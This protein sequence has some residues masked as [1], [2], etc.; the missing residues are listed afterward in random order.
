MLAAMPSETLYEELSCVV[1][2][3]ID[4][5]RGR[6]EHTFDDRET[7]DKDRASEARWTTLLSSGSPS[8]ERDAAR[9]E[10]TAT[11]ETIDRDRHAPDQASALLHQGLYGALSAEALDGSNRTRTDTTKAMETIDNDRH[12]LGAASSLVGAGRDLYSALSKPAGHSGLDRGRTEITEAT[13][14]IDLDK[15]PGGLHA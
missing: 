1:P 15:P 13:E 7:V 3:A 9:T 11:V 8:V 14:T 6:T 2:S 4:R 5:D 12:P 10:Q